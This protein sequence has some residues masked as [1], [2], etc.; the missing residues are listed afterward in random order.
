MMLTASSMSQFLND[1]NHYNSKSVLTKRKLSIP[2]TEQDRNDSNLNKKSTNNYIS[3][4]LNE[5]FT[6]LRQL[7]DLKTDEAD[8][9]NI[10]RETIQSVKH[11]RDSNAILNTRSR[12]LYNDIIRLNSQVATFCINTTKEKTVNF[13][14]QPIKTNAVVSECNIQLKETKLPTNSFFHKSCQSAFKKI[15]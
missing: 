15:S 3:E 9:V 14:T 4:D 5:E 2:I 7:L 1:F 8:F 12:S 13:A 10:L 6:N 11:L